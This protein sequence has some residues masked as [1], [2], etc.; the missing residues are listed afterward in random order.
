MTALR[1]TSE[2]ARMLGISEWSVRKLRKNGQLVPTFVTTSGAALFS[3][4]E[5]ERAK[6]V[7]SSRGNASSHGSN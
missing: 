5:I 6:S 2:V 1:Q 7:R 3:D 4:D